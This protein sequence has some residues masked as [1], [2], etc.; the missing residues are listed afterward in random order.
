MS[1]VAVIGG[2][3]IGLSTAVVAQRRMPWLE[4]TVFA[5]QLSPDTTGDGSAGLW[6]PYLL[7][8]TPADNI[9]RWASET[10]FLFREL[11]QSPLAGEVGVSLVPMTWLTQEEGSSLPLWRHSVLGFSP[12]D[13]KQLRDLSSQHGRTYKFGYEM[14]MFT[15][16][17][18]RFLPYL[19]KEFKTNGGVLLKKRVTSLPDVAADGYDVVVN[20][21][22]LGARE[23]VGD[24][25]IQPI[26]G[27][28]MRVKAPWVKHV[29]LDDSD[30]G[31][32]II[33]NQDSVV[34]GG[35]HQLGDWNTEVSSADRD[36][37]LN[38]C[39]KMLPAL[40]RAEVLQEWVGLRPSR[41]QVRLER[42]TVRG[43]HGKS[44]EVVH[45]YGHGGSGVTLCWGCA[46]DA[47]KLIQQSLQGAAKL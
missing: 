18:T 5:E 9:N 45:N 37:I 1:R 30:A 33:P 32:Y 26:R 7:Q 40:R 17:P 2:G 43:R 11:W 14:L 36:F 29:I 3:V 13:E 41:P 25:S 24:V 34:L 22:G 15:C 12:I 44:F 4:V 39:C 35:T 21:S 6:E 46:Q 28:V 23:L 27:Q 19:L 10:Y 16:E 42:E 31:N 38:G 47:V 8:D 20:C